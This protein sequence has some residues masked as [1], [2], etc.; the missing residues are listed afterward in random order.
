MLPSLRF[1]YHSPLKLVVVHYWAYSNKIKM[2]KWV[3]K[4]LYSS[5]IEISKESSHWTHWRWWLEILANKSS[6]FLSGARSIRN[7]VQIKQRVNAPRQLN[8]PRTRKNWNPWENEI[9]RE[10][11]ERVMLT[12]HCLPNEEKLK[13]LYRCYDKVPSGSET[14]KS[15][16]ASKTKENSDLGNPIHFIQ[17]WC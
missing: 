2:N 11:K 4:S 7:K 1:L 6:I 13:S 16:T 15:P 5:N 8:E 12:L 3:L 17:T 9:H 10:S 14:W